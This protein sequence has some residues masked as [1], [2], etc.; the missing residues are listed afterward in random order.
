MDKEL[1]KKGGAV[2]LSWRKKKEKEEFAGLLARHSVL[3][4]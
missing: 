2:V 4:G 1:T 3:R